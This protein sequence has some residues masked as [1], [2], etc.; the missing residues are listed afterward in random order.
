VSSEEIYEKIKELGIDYSQGYLF[1]V[2][3]ENL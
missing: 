2:P 1:S 3:N